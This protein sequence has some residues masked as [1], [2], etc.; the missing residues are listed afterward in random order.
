VRLKCDD[1]KPGKLYTTVKLYI[2]KLIFDN[3]TQWYLDATNTVVQGSVPQVIFHEKTVNGFDF[4]QL[5]VNTYYDYL[6]ENYQDSVELISFQDEADQE[7][8]YQNLGIT[9]ARPVTF[10]TY[11]P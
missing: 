9:Y 10:T 8:V 6:K 5:M 3:A 2:R 1:V 7:Y 11:M 4:N